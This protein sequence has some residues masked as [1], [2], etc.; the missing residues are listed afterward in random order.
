MTVFTNNKNIPLSVA[1]WL[2]SNSY[3]FKPNMKSLSATDFNKSIR[4]II[5]RNRL[6]MEQLEAPSVD[7]STLIKSKLGTACHDAIEHS[8][9]NDHNRAKALEDLGYSQNTIDIIKVNPSPDELED[10]HV[11]VY[12]ERRG[13]IE[14]NGYTISGKFDFVADGILTDFKTTGTWKWGTLGKANIEY[15][16]QGSIYKLIHSDII[17]KDYLNIVFIFTDWIQGRANANESY[18]PAMCVTHKVPLY[19][20]DET[21]SL[22]TDFTNELEKYK[23]APEMELPDCNASHLWQSPATYKYYK[24]PDKLSRA[25]K[26]FD[27]LYEAENYRLDR[28]TGI[29]IQV[30]GEV[31]ACHTCPVASICSQKERL[32][33]IGLLK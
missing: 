32:K 31:K 4:Q 29:V 7:I 1:L 12:L 8:W 14:V 30:M 5:L 19:S 20:N 15:R 21:V 33:Q 27:S 25:T 18:P 23:D 2:A 11:P 24:N 13:S 16:N 22:I 17:T 3:D 6:I 9:L 28:K 10:H 26:V